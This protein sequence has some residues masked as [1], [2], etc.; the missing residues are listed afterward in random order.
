MKMRL[1]ILPPPF[2]E[3]SLGGYNLRLITLNRYPSSGYIYE[4]F[5]KQRLA[6]N[7]YKADITKIDL[8]Q[9]S[10]LL[11]L[12]Q[13]SILSML[14]PYK[15]PPSLN[16]IFDNH[17]QTYTNSKY[18]SINNRICPHCLKEF[19]YIKKYWDI[20]FVTTCLEHNCL[21]VEECPGC[22]KK[23]KYNRPCIFTCKCGFD[24]RDIKMSELDISSHMVTELVLSKCGYKNV[25]TSSVLTKITYE[26]LVETFLLIIRQIYKQRYITSPI[27]ELKLLHEYLIKTYNFFEK[28]PSNFYKIL[29]EYENYSG[30][31]FGIRS[32]GE[33][34]QISF[35]KRTSHLKIELFREAFKNYI[36]TKWSNGFASLLNNVNIK[37]KDHVFVNL[38]RTANILNKSEESIKELLKNGKLE[39]RVK[40]KGKTNYYLINVESINEFKIKNTKLY[41]STF[42]Q[43]EVQKMLNV[44]HTVIKKLREE[45]MLSIANSPKFGSNEGY[46][47]Y[48]QEVR[49]IFDLL[50]KNLVEYQIDYNEWI[51][52][53]KA[54]EEL[55]CS[56]TN[57]I[58]YLEKQTLLV[59]KIKG[60]NFL[61]TNDYLFNR[62]EINNEAR[63]G[64]NGYTREE[65]GK[66]FDVSREVVKDWLECGLLN[67]DLNKSKK[68]VRKHH[69]DEFRKKYI[70]V[71]SIDLNNIKSVK[72]KI[73]Y[74]ESKGIYPVESKTGQLF[75]ISELN[76]NI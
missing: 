45:G 12:Q 14:S 22:G 55:N 18:F 59:Y 38:S 44:N 36:E 28:W 57:F 73:K 53:G 69:V 51:S 67:F 17:Y 8:E 63:I 39:G 54:R 46:R 65:L 75:R 27:L 34:Y 3:E 24:Y 64:I 70:P 26:E 74:F 11:E 20:F 4:F 13:E 19:R 43:S 68:I 32:F 15:A 49:Y 7:P 2:E 31:I 29:D 47:Y 25:E 37:G 62:K 48:F 30:S 56:F 42:F 76:I 41:K 61:N 10:L 21:L 40:K 16:L 72:G 5:T 35:G 9:L 50:E 52:F 71:K 6:N 60:S 66:M 58:K 23:I 1:L 33:L